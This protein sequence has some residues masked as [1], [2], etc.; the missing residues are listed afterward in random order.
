[1]KV[2]SPLGVLKYETKLLKNKE[3]VGLT[4][5]RKKQNKSLHK[6]NLLN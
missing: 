3:F 4:D 1:M 5:P 6:Q 2:K